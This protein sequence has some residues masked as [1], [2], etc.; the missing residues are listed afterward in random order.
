[1]KELL[2]EYNKTLSENNLNIQFNEKRIKEIQYTFQNAHAL[3]ISLRKA[4]DLNKEFKNLEQDLVIFK[5]ARSDLQFITTWIKTGIQPDGHWRGIE[6]NDAYYINRPYD[7]QMMGILIE[8]KQAN[9]PF[10]MVEESFSNVEEKEEQERIRFDDSLTRDTA[11]LFEQ[12]KEALTRNEI[13]ILLFIQENRSQSEMA[14]LI[15]VSQQAI[16]KRIKS[17]KKKLSKLGIERDDL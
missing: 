4:I 3:K 9:E 15:G 12:A 10:E 6:K 14:K 7:P 17:I 16:S 11:E 13:K 2:E 1:M 5:A 8:N